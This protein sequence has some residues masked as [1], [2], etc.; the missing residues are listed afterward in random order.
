MAGGILITGSTGQVGGA[1]LHVLAPQA[2]TLGELCA[3][4]RSEMDLGDGDSI[5][6]AIRS[7]RPRWIINAGAYTAV[8]KAETEPEI[9][10]KI[11]IEAPRILG[12]EASR[13]GAAVLHLST[14]YVFSGE[15]TA[16]YTEQDAT[17]PV[18]VYG[19]TKLAGEQTLA[20]ATPA[21]LI[22]RTS[23]VYG[24][25]GKNFLLTV[26]RLARE[27]PVMKIVADQYGAPT[28]SYDLARLIGHVIA[29]CEAAAAADSLSI[30]MAV[31]RVSGI[32]H[33]VSAGE[34]TWHGFAHEAVRQMQVRE[35]ET[36][37]AELQPI[38]TAEYPTPARRPLNSR[39]DCGKLHRTL[40]WQMPAWRESLG[41]VI[42]KL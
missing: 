15:G 4:G 41:T 35:P 22:F 32:Y 18:S 10:A 23:W 31:E 29:R 5:R 19:A 12:E 17:G 27:R 38:S 39:L 26:L 30:D 1:L 9:A 36:R 28:W 21:H 33:A 40:G 8:D 25:T 2:S 7:L 24:A 14:D 6:T 3:P 37:F 11:N 20:A 13:I 34:T 16:A 42:A